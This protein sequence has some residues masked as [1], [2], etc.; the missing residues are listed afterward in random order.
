M[1][2]QL[3]MGDNFA[4]RNSSCQLFKACY[5]QS[6]PHKD[7]LREIFVQLTKEDT[8]L[9]RKECAKQLG[10]FAKQVEKSYVI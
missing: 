7:K 8:P 1:V 6:G 4:H 10:L 5:K 9:I 3:A 2:M